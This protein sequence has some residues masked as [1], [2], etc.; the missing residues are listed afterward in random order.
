MK[1]RYGYIGGCFGLVLVVSV[2][3]TL[4]PVATLTGRQS[5]QPREARTSP[6]PERA[7]EQRSVYFPDQYANEAKEPAAPIATF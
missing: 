7:W 4:Q 5:D 1:K 6:E 3:C 2:L